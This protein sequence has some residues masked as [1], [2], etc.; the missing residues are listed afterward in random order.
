[1]ES[2]K[3]TRRRWIQSVRH[4]CLDHFIIVGT[5]HFNY[6]IN[7]YIDH[8]N[9]ERPHQGRENVPLTGDWSEPAI[10]GE[11]KC[12]KRLG[13]VLRHYYREAA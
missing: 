11:I 9:T 8:Y 6:L 2:I 10:A 12:K 13:G 5:S 7:E 1:M 4:E 3:C